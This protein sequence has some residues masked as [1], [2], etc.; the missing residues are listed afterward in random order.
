MI[1][2]KLTIYIKPTEACNLNCLHCYNKYKDN[3]SV[4]DLNKLRRFT[5]S[6]SEYIYMAGKHFELDVV[7]HGGEPTMVGTQMLRDIYYIIAPKFAHARVKFSIQTNLTIIDKDFL[8]FAKDVLGGE[9]GTSY[10]PRL[11]FENMLE[12]DMEQVWRNNIAMCIE[13]K[14]SVYLV[15]SLSKK[16]IK[17]TDPATLIEFLKDTEVS[18]FHFEP[19]TPNGLAA[20]NWQ[21]IA[22][23]PDEYDGWKAEFAKKFI[24]T[25]SYR[26]F[27]ESEIV[28]KAKTFFD[29]SFVGCSC[30]DCMLTVMTINADGTIG[31]CP[32]VSK[33]LII[34][35][36][37][38]PF[39]S[40]SDSVARQLLIVDEHRKRQ[41]CLDCD[42]FQQC[43]GGCMQTSACFEGREF[44]KE[45]ELGLGRN[46]DFKAF[47][48]EY[49]RN[50][51]YCSEKVMA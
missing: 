50:Q 10:S 19:I 37:D 1:K 27:K 39:K 24:D 48:K 49:S 29:G 40:F 41:E 25:G 42:F 21:D 18:G 51:S 28:R 26:H 9:I 23:E 47:V 7:F 2:D 22:A 15:I 44:F 43:N 32:N 6:M 11:R 30:R 46:A 3:S 34:S 38:E 31:L 12:R 4:I 35:T 14:L 8:G 17:E 33:E 36:M 13:N 45:L 16:Y 20:A 5:T